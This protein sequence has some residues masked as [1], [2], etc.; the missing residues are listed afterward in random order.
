MQ[1]HVILTG[2][3]IHSR[4]YVSDEWLPRLEE[5]LRKYAK[6][7]DIFRGDS[8]QAEVSVENCIRMIF[9]LKAAMRQLEGV[10]VRIG[11]GVGEIDVMAKSIKKSSGEAFVLSGQALDNLSKESVEFRSRWN[12]LNEPMN[13]ILTLATRLTDQWTTN[14]AETVHSALDNPQSNQIELTKIIGRKHQSQVSTELG[15][16]NYIKINQVIDYCTQEIKRYVN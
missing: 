13:L 2:D 5:G 15:K 1:Y 11:I 4:S 14:M 10:D 8:F 9:Y 3:I 7:F 12:E 6:T 16:A